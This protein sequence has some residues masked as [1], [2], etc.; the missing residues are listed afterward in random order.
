MRRS[1]T[2]T[3][4][5]RVGN[6]LKRV[7]VEKADDDPLMQEVAVNLFYGEKQTEIEHFHPYGFTA[8]VKPPTTEGKDKRKAEGVLVFTGGNRSHGITLIIGDRRYRLRKLKEGEVALHDDQGQQ[9]HLSRDGVFVSVPKSKK[10]VTQIM[11]DDKRPEPDDKDATTKKYGQAAQAGKT[12]YASMTLTQDSLVIDHPK[13]VL[14]KVGG[15]SLEMLP[16]K[17]TVTSSLIVTDGVNHLGGEGVLKKVVRDGDPEE[18]VAT[19]ARVF[20]V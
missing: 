1:T 16:D 6:A 18:N 17:A 12:A 7:T 4:G 3:L 13:K 11:A 15:T 10:V 19:T 20:A 14:L 5:D 9:V 2:R 8:R